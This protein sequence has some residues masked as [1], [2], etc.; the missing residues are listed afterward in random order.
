MAVAVNVTG[1]PVAPV[2]LALADCGPAWSP[3][4]QRLVL[5]PLASVWSVPGPTAPAAA[6]Q[7]T[8]TSGSGVP[9]RVTTT[10]RLEGS[11]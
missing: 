4:T 2:T 1:D 11:A 7:V 5:S 9:S 6:L 3:S 8:A 10:R